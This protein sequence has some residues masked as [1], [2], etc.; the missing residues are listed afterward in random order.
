MQGYF[1]VKLLDAS[2][3]KQALRELE[4]VELLELLDRMPIVQRAQGSNLVFDN[5]AAYVFFTLFSGGDVQD[6][7]DT[8]GTTLNAYFST[9]VLQTTDT[10]PAYT[11]FSTQSATADAVTGSIGGGSSFKRFIEDDV[12]AELIQAGASG[13][14]VVTFRS[15]FLWSSAEGNSSSIKSLGAWYCAD[16]DLT[17][18]QTRATAA[19]IRLK[20]S[21]GNPITVVKDSSKVLLVEYTFTLAA[22]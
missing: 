11:D 6:P 18:S 2:D 20:D 7:F 8:G 19:R 15:R 1:D 16:A 12:E 13:R 14:E 3:Y 5:F 9:L 4:G 22:I 17:T 21:G 10:E